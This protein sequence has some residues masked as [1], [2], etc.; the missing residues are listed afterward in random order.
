MTLLQDYRPIIRNGICFLCLFILPIVFLYLEIKYWEEEKSELIKLFLLSNI[1]C[2]IVNSINYLKK[3]IELIT[4]NHWENKFF[5]MYITTMIHFSSFLTLSYLILF[6]FFIDVNIKSVISILVVIIIVS[7]LAYCLFICFFS[8]F[9][10]LFSLRNRNEYT[11]VNVQPRKHISI[12]IISY[13]S[14]IDKKK[15]SNI[16]YICLVEFELSNNIVSILPCGHI[17]DYSCINSWL[18][19]KYTCPV[20]RFDLELL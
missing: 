11:E 6:T 12:E 10:W 1:C 19:L 16:C 15:Y 14:I 13:N 20:C 2:M 8:F 17:F 9:K 7:E 18:Q 4:G 5:N 3:I